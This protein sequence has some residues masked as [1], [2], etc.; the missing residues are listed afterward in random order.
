MGVLLHSLG[1]CP[2]AGPAG[3]S[4]GRPILYS[5][6]GIGHDGRG[7]TVLFGLGGVALLFISPIFIAAGLGLMLL[8]LALHVFRRRR[9]AAA[10]A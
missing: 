8:G 9:L 6:A 5:G 2:A 1:D 4:A 10:M 3:F 7:S